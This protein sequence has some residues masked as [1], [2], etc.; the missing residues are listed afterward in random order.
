MSE[1]EKKGSPWPWILVPVAAV[2]M[3]FVLRECRQK[4][5][6]APDH[7]PAAAATVPAT[8]ESPAPADPAPA[9]PEAAPAPAPV[10]Q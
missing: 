8:P 2:S 9:E 5:P 7:S 10:P 6:P 1:P 4:L 3:F